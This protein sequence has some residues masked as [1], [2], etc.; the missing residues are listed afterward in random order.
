MKGLEL[1]RYS[2]YKIKQLMVVKFP[3][4]CSFGTVGTEDGVSL[5][6]HYALLYNSYSMQN[7]RDNLL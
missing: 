1:T 5:H 2:S 4:P 3:F 6:I 7:H